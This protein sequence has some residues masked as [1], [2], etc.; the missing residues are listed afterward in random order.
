VPNA[1]LT[2]QQPLVVVAATPKQMGRPEEGRPVAAARGESLSGFPHRRNRSSMVERR[3]FSLHRSPF[4]LD[5]LPPRKGFFLNLY[6]S[7]LVCKR[8]EVEILGFPNAHL[9][10]H[11]VP[12]YVGNPDATKY[13]RSAAA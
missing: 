6:A 4:G 11:F 13:T 10:R 7:R 5:A 3:E 2:G 1:T 8:P 12:P 9:D